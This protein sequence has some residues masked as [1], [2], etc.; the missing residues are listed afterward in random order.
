MS[1]QWVQD[2]RDQCSSARVPFMFKQ[3]GEWLPMLGQA[4]GVPV[5]DKA[6]TADGWVMARAGK[7]AA[8]RRLDGELHDEYP[9]LDLQPV[10]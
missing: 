9:R 10:D 3:W 4:E 1:P 7:K 5:R 2:I 6:T 8:G